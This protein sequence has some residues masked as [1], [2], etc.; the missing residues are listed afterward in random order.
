MKLSYDNKYLFT[1]GQDGLVI[2]HDI[3]DREDAKGQS[4]SKQIKDDENKGLPWSDEILTE[5][6]EIEGYQTEKEQLE[7]DFNN[8]SQPDSVDKLMKMKKLED[9]IA[10]AND[11]LSN[12]QVQAKNRYD[13]VNENKREMENSFE[14]KI[15][16]L[17]EQF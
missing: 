4:K 13:S 11:D 15:K 5:K 3:K 8:A 2:I 16:Q 1:G 9:A 17:A 12:S 6:T 7:N 10:K 14:E